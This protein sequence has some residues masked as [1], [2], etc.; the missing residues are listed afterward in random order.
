MSSSALNTVQET[1]AL[2]E[3]PEL[4]PE[5]GANHCVSPDT[6]QQTASTKS[7]PWE[8]T[9]PGKAT[10]WNGLAAGKALGSWWAGCELQC[11][12]AA[13]TATSILGH[14]QDVE[15]NNRSPT[16][17]LLNSIRN[18]IQFWASRTRSTL[19]TNSSSMEGHHNDPRLECCLLR[20][21]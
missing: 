11:A 3:V 14:S 8:G 6:P 18:C 19:T 12:P 9:S 21:G 16:Q 7:C 1:E 15:A 2:S 10:G 20:G 4:W 13:Q 17:H 5:D